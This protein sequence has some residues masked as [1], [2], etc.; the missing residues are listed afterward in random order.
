MMSSGSAR[1]M[2]GLASVMLCSA[3]KR[4]IAA[5]RSTTEWNTPC[6]RCRRCLNITRQKSALAWAKSFSMTKLLEHYAP[7][8]LIPSWTS[9]ACAVGA[10]NA[11]RPHTQKPATLGGAKWASTRVRHSSDPAERLQRAHRAASSTDAESE[12]TVAHGAPLQSFGSHFCGRSLAC[13][14]QA[15]NT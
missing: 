11:A 4:L 7:C 9:A 1:Q 3:M 12:G 15:S 2:K 13:A 14:V 10:G 5:C 8:F 6:F